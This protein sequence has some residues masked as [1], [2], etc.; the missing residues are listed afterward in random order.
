M[1]AAASLEPLEQKL[2]PNTGFP[3]RHTLSKIP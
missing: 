3:F 2:A 1:R